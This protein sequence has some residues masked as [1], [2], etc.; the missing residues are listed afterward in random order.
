MSQR[1]LDALLRPKSIA[2]IGASEKPE[3][4]GSVIIKNLLSSGFTGPILPVTPNK[5]AVMGILTY[6]TIDKLPFSPDLAVI[7]TNSDRNLTCL[8]QLGKMGCKAAIILSSPASQ[9]VKLKALTQRYNIRLLGPNSLGILAPWQQLNASFSPIPIL[10]G[11]LAFISQSAAVSN[12]ILDWAQQR[13]IGFSYFIALGNSLDIDIDDLL[14][15]LARDNKT[16]AIL[17]YIE[18][19]QQARRFLSAA[20][21]ASRN[22]P[23]LV[24]KSGRTQQAQYLLGEVQ[25][26]DAAYD[27]AIQR[28]G[29]LLGARYP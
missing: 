24:V 11:K 10:K 12:I 4:A 7:C 27:A 19:I 6:P 25:S 18:H 14:D 1:G 17:L 8:T 22:K 23:I 20:R 13:T 2:V 21:S 3:R 16:S 29:L 28:A 15:F 5:N 9:F 26:F